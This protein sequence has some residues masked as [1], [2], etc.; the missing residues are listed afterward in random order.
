MQIED[1]A[2]TK[3][4]S[5]DAN[6]RRVVGDVR[7]EAIGPNASDPRT[8]DKDTEANEALHGVLNA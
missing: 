7:R 6:V 8:L 3:L 1:I 4:E 5:S 2:I